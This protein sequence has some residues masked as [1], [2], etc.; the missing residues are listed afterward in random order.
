MNDGQPMEIYDPPAFETGQ[1]VRSRTAIRNDG[2][3]PGVKTG[4]IIVEAG[5]VGYVAN[6]GEHLQRYYVYTVDFIT[7]GRFV[8]MR[9]HEIE[10]LED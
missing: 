1:K 8:G 6:I 3:M 2:T 4:E 7:R 10:P 5:D 9:R